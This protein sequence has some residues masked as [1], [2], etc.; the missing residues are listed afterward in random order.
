MKST[1]FRNKENLIDPQLSFSIDVVRGISAIGV[2][3][4][5]SMPDPAFYPTNLNG[6]FWVWIFLCLSGF[7]V[8]KSFQSGSYPLSASGYFRFLWN[9]GLRLVPL[10]Q[11][12]LIFGFLLHIMG[13]LKFDLLGFGKQFFFLTYDMSFAGP[14]WTVSAEIHFY[15]ISLFLFLL[16]TFCRRIWLLIPVVFLGVWISGLAVDF[17]D[18]LH[19]PRSVLGNLPFF[20]IGLILSAGGYSG[21]IVVPRIVKIV[22]IITLVLVAFLFNNGSG[23]HNLGL[24]GGMTGFYMNQW[25]WSFNAELGVGGTIFGV[26]KICAIAIAVCT[27]CIATKPSRDPSAILDRVAKC[28]SWC[29]FYTYGIYCWHISIQNINN[30]FIHLNP[31]VVFLLLTMCAI[32]IAPYSYHIF[33]SKFF[34]YKYSS[35]GRYVSKNA[36]SDSKQLS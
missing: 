17:G 18:D 30:H 33:E 4:G 12:T 35:R 32:P 31:G 27:V 36:A 8:G 25:F 2:I 21:V 10:F 23:L 13:N 11:L 7:L 3:W 24:I 22:L 34:K 16:L 20:L 1:E 26:G 28:F 15:M 29:G 9:R 5:H 19:A 14:L 6:A